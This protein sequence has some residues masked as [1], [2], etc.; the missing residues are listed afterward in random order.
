MC[1]VVWVDLMGYIWEGGGANG[2]Q[3]MSRAMGSRRE[4]EG[5]GVWYAMRISDRPTGG[6]G[7]KK[8]TRAGGAKNQG[9]KR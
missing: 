1:V 7:L 5:R 3:R 2:K 9:S 4:R 6:N 8:R